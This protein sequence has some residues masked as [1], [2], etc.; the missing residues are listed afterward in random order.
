MNRQVANLLYQHR[1]NLIKANTVIILN[2][3]ESINQF[4]IQQIKLNFFNLNEAECDWWLKNGMAACSINKLI[5][6]QSTNQ[7]IFLR[8]EERVVDFLNCWSGIE[9]LTPP[10]RS[11]AQQIQIKDNFY[12]SLLAP[13]ARYYRSHQPIVFHNSKQSF[14]LLQTTGI[15]LL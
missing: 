7:S 2:V 14:S 5:P 10:C 11:S 12:F 3:V 9:L 1:F 4:T 13:S 15:F 8:D 6:Q